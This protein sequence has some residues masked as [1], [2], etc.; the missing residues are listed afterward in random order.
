MHL[1]KS[2][3]LL[4]RLFL[5]FAVLIWAI[6]G[7]LGWYTISNEREVRRELM[8]QQLRNVN[9]TIIDAYGRGYDLQEIVNFIKFY[10]DNTTFDELRVT[11]YDDYGEA[12]AHSGEQ[13]LI[14]DSEHR[15]L[16]ELLEAEQYG[17]AH[18][19]HA[20]LINRTNSIFQVIVSNDGEIRTIAA[21]P[22]SSRVSSELGYD[23]LIW[24]LAIGLAFAA[25]AL[26]FGLANRSRMAVETLHD[27]AKKAGKGEI[28]NIDIEFPKSE[29]GDVSREILRLYQDKDKAMEQLK[30]EHQVA[31]RANEEKER[32]K[33]QSANNINHEL[34]TPVSVIKGYLDTIVSDPD[35]PAAMRDNFISKARDHAERLSQLLK[36]VSSITRLEDGSQQVEISQFD[37]HDLIY[38]IA[39][40]LDASHVNEDVS[41]E[42]DVPFDTVVSGNYTLLNN[43]IM[44]LIRN[45][46]KHSHGTKME[47]SLTGEDE[48]FYYFEFADNGTGVGEEHIPHLF[49]RF[50]RVD[51]GRARK[52][53]GTGLG[54]P[55]VKS[56]FTALG[57]EI[58]VRNA[59]PH[60]LVFAFKLPKGKAE[61]KETE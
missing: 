1:R 50:Y 22:F 33:R 36:D 35:M 16:P 39:N 23:A 42:W 34:K 44:N 54:L 2:S 55:I 61:D 49:D 27:F 9:S 17:E 8:L 24:F 45:A 4:L 32:I 3:N 13:I 51:E 10:N 12:I 56:T 11:V 5:P 31:M 60:G 26:A 18:A 21:L 28:N 48:T 58:T 40:D 25:T 52:S 38:N 7:L 43:A 19:A 29:L 47:L 53:G 59:L 15:I 30:H 46:V 14:E 20:S 37:F 6:I 41:F 57:G